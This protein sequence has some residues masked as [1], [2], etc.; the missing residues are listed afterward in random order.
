MRAIQEF[1][2]RIRIDSIFELLAYI[3]FFY[4]L[5]K[6]FILHRAPVPSSAF[7]S[8]PKE[9]LAECVTLLKKKEK[10]EYGV[11]RV[12]EEILSILRADLRNEEN[13]KRLLCSICAHLGIDGGFIKLVVEDT[14]MSD[15]AGEIAT[16]LA[17]TTI[18][19]ELKPHYTPEAVIAVLAHEAIHLHL[20]YAGIRMR[21]TWEN[22]I[23]TDTAAVYCGFGEYIYA[24]YAVMRGEFAFSYQKVGYIRQED[25]QYI[26]KIMQKEEGE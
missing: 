3:G 19:L 23:L 16:D 7:K 2:Y 11:Y 20:Y 1:L 17:F 25:V 13:L 15:R 9:L 22:E 12:P 4:F 5:F 8:V 6:R 24:G 18:R 10:A 26:W 14:F 21:D